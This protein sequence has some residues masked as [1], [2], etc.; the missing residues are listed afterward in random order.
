MAKKRKTSSKKTPAAASSQGASQQTNLTESNLV[1]KGMIKDT[2]SSFQNKESWFHARNAI[3]NSI[4]G[5]LGTLGNEPANLR[6]A[7][8]PY[9]VIGGIH[10]YGDK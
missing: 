2:N 3:N 6:C 9:T 10:L 4:D 7:E 8:I 1:S 5:D